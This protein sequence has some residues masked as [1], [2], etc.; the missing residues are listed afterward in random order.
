MDHGVGKYFVRWGIGIAIIGFFLFIVASGSGRFS[1]PEGVVLITID[2]LRPDH[3][4]C[5]G[6]GKA[7]SP[8]LDQIAKKGIVFTRAFATG[9]W[10]LSSVPSI[11]TSLYQS[12][13]RI[14]Y[15]GDTLNVQAVTLAELLRKKGYR[16]GFMGPFFFKQ[17]RG[18]E[19]GFEDFA[20]TLENEKADSLTARA[21]AWL[22]SNQKKRFFLWLHYFDSHAPYTPPDPYNKMFVSLAPG[23]SARQL[24]VLPGTYYGFGGIPEYARLGDYRDPEYYI[25]QYDGAIRFVDD[26]IA[27]V[28]D[29]L[30]LLGLD[31]KT[32]VVITSD[33]GEYLGEHGIYFMHNGIPLDTVIRV[34]FIIYYGNRP[35]AVHSTGRFVSLIDIAPTILGYVRSEIPRSMQGKSVLPLLSGENKLIHE[36]VYCGNEFVSALRSSRYK[37]IKID[38]RGLT[39]YIAHK[40][41]EQQEGYGYF[42]DEIEYLFNGTPEYAI[43]DLEKDVS[44][45]RTVTVTASAEIEM[46]KKRLELW[47]AS[48]SIAPLN[49]ERPPRQVVDKNDAEYLRSLGYLQ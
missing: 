46:L 33:H 12:T 24:D 40:N 1:P 9:T 43:F 48:T 45:A 25:S 17:M 4:G 11:A 8:H 32:L 2:A 20:A 13:H 18:I 41:K 30:R 7:T 31:K 16:T 27:K 42:R 21:V 44:E 23:D 26:N 15:Y 39:D 19:R 34:P 6:Y 35:P 5:Y 37:V 3:L 22:K 14:F 28:M 36:Y 47:K 29:T 38:Y 49:Q 10:T